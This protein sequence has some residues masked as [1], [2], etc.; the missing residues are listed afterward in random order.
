MLTHHRHIGQNIMV[1]CGGLGTAATPQK[2][3]EFYTSNHNALLLLWRSLP[4]VVQLLSHIAR[5]C[6]TLCGPLDCSM[7]GFP[8]LHYL[9]EFVQTHV[10]WVSDAIQPSY[11]LHPLLLLPSI[12][13]SIRLFSSESALS[14][15]WPKYWTF[16][17]SINPSDEHSGLIFFRIDW[18]DLFAV[19][20]S[21]KSLFQHHNLKASILSHSAFFMVQFS[22]LYMTIGKTI[23][24]TI[25][26]SVGKVMSLILIVLFRFVIDLLPRCKHLIIS[27]LHSP[28]AVI[29]EC[30]SSYSRLTVTQLFASAL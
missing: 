12:F 15:W 16:S 4:I 5:L 23:A 9:S 10:H 14:I 30:F 29:L 20:G 2:K 24:L 7:L 28:S 18:F 11:P 19:Q 13:P 22:Q 3:R 8:V 26:T 17:F 21:L 25:W 1:P 27:W 6:P